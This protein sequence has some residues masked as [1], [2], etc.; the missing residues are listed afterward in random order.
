MVPV[1]LVPHYYYT[2]TTLVLILLYQRVGL[3]VFVLSKAKVGNL[4][5]ISQI[6]Q[7]SLPPLVAKFCRNFFPILL[8]TKICQVIKSFGSVKMNSVCIFCS[9]YHFSRAPPGDRQNQQYQQQ[10]PSLAPS[11]CHLVVIAIAKK[12]SRGGANLEITN[13]NIPPFIYH[14]HQGCTDSNWSADKTV[15]GS[16]TSIL[17]VHEHSFPIALKSPNGKL[18]LITYDSKLMTHIYDSSV[19][20]T[21]LTNAV[22]F[23]SIPDLVYYL[24]NCK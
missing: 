3:V 21:R 20:H 24:N 5:C 14:S 1:R 23:S 2:S 8:Q 13:C 12:S 9:I 7:L 16:L 15:R 19:T 11:L 22:S 4:F 10:Q 6:V 18:D 17:F